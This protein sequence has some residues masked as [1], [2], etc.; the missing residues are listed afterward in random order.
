MTLS[1]V[2]D[3]ELVYESTG[4]TAMEPSGKYIYS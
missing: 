2:A 4:T 3:L 1:E